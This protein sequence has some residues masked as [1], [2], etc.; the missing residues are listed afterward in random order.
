[1]GSGSILIR[2]HS[3]LSRLPIAVFLWLLAGSAA[4]AFD[5][6]DLIMSPEQEKRIG[7]EE[8]GRILAQFGG[9]YDDPELA[10]YVKSIGDFLVLTSSAS[11]TRFTFTVL[12]SPVVNAFA[13]PGGYVYVT[14]G[15]VALADTE[16]ELA[17]VLAHEIGHVAARHGA[18]RQTQSVLANLGLLILGAATES[19]TAVG[20]GQIGASAVI[21]GYSR[22]DEYEADTLGV[23]YLSRAG[24]SPDAMSSFLRK[25]ESHH[26]LE[27]N[28]RGTSAS[29]GLGFFATHPRTADRVSRA[30]EK[31]GAVHVNNPIV[32]RDIYQKKVDGI[33]FGDDPAQ[34][35]IEGQRFIHPELGFQF[36]V[37]KGFVLQNSPSAVIAQG[38]NGAGIKF[39]LDKRD[40]RSSMTNYLRRVW[41]PDSR[42]SNLD[43]FY[44]DGLPAA[45]AVVEAVQDGQADARLVAIAFDRDTIYRFV[46][47]IP[48]RNASY[49]DG[50]YR[51]TTLSF[52]RISPA[53]GSRI[54]PKRLRIY[55]VRQG[56]TSASIAKRFPYPSYRLDRFL[57][58]NGL[59]GGSVLRPGERVKIVY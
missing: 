36:T 9:A 7:A 59:G 49:I 33:I 5:L 8:H 53:E 10:A 50:E 41:A 48:Q 47:I 21:S 6:T 12:N 32:A 58:L 45:T 56:D 52:R 14:R 57:V 4:V 20:L 26:N 40:T 24:F 37:P 31:A 38:T 30:I 43:S 39:D 1:M 16:A 23:R 3:K 29:Q 25:L 42:L 34:G 13:L 15:L 35:V 27:A 19:S 44:V 54:K 18:Q 11:S 55:E 51:R 28:I 46:F 22:E 17:G 2:M